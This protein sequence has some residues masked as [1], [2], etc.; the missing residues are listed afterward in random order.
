MESSKFS[1]GQ[2]IYYLFMDSICQS[3]IID[4]KKEGHQWI[5]TDALFNNI[6]EEYIFLTKKDCIEFHERGIRK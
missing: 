5:Y 2:K 4:V 6:K 3:K 1:K